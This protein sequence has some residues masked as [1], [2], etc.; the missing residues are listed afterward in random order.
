MKKIHYLG[1]FFILLSLTSSFCAQRETKHYPYWHQKVSLF[2]QLPN[3][4]NEIIFLGDSIT[5]GGNWTELFKDLR[6]KNRGINGDTTDGI[7]DRLDEITESNPLKIFLMIGI[8]DLADG[9]SIEYITNNIKRIIKTINKDSPET[10]IYIESILPVNS[11]FGQFKNHTNKTTE[12]IIIN[13]ALQK[14]A[15]SQGITYIDLFSLFATEKNKLNPEYTNEGLHLTGA[16]YL[17]WK[18]AIEK[19]INL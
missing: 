19:F 18:S 8:N 2:K 14:Y 9:K 11:D 1:L 4:K 3:T 7:L 12:I 5:D 6:I 10:Q 17:L 13:N 15:R 16:G